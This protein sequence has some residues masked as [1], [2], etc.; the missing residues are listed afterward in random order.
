MMSNWNCCGLFGPKVDEYEPLPESKLESESVSIG[1][2]L[3]N[4]PSWC[5]SRYFEDDVYVAIGQSS[6]KEKLAHDLKWV[7][8]GFLALGLVPLGLGLWWQFSPSDMINATNASGFGREIASYTA[9]GISQL[10]GG[11][12]IVAGCGL[13]CGAGPKTEY[14]QPRNAKS[15][16]IVPEE[17]QYDKSEVLTEGDYLLIGGATTAQSTEESSLSLHNIRDDHGGE[18]FKLSKLQIRETRTT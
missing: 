8:A 13:D 7:G 4:A 1:Q 11:L 16:S 18:N 10:I 9:A 5:C 2:K 17:D 6:P 15:Q 12:S 14:S 3:R